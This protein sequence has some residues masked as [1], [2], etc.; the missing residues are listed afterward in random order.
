MGSSFAR[1]RLN[2]NIHKEQ[3]H[4]G[5]FLVFDNPSSKGDSSSP[6]LDLGGGGEL[7]GRLPIRRPSNPLT[8]NIL[9][10]FVRIGL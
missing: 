5:R 10:L 4:M 2:R 8:I 6:S 1:V 9:E 7:D 3:H